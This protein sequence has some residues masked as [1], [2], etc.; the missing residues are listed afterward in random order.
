[1]SAVIATKQP[2]PDRAVRLGLACLYLEAL[3]A[4]VAAGTPR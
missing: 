4:S 1:M 2:E 3:A